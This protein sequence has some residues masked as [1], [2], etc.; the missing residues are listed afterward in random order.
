VEA[1]IAAERAKRAILWLRESAWPLWLE[2]GV[3]WRKRA[4]HE[5]LRLDSLD[6]TASFRRLR[7]A[8]R[9]TYVFSKAAGHG[10]PRAKEAVELG[11]GFLRGPARLVEGGVAWRFDLDS[12]PVDLTRDLYDHAF[13]LLAFSAAAPVMGPDSLRQDACQL[14]DYIDTRFRHAE[15][16]Y[17]ESIPST[18]P[19]RQNPHMHLLEA[20][21]AAHDSFGEVVYFERAQALI[22]LFLDRFFQPNDGALPEYFDGRLSP[23]REQNRQYIIEPGHHYEW[24]W[25]LDWYAKSAAAMSRQ[26]RPELGAASEALLKFTDRFAVDRS[27]GLVFNE[28]WSDGSLRSGDFR[29]W[30]QTE[31]LKAEARR[32]EHADKCTG[33]AFTAL[34]KHL[35][36]V[37]PGLWRERINADGI[38]PDDPAPAT[39]LYHLTAALT[40]PAVVAYA[41][42][43]R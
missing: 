28:L 7:V 34:W 15:A 25:L 24:I 19:R 12:K 35:D 38:C 30:P 20:L 18:Q 42:S 31:R 36:G 26:V 21:L 17:E 32:H 9:Q 14:L 5:H 4:F 23:L 13:V 39:S 8:A 33:A 43:G 2:H 10:V 22:D 1:D 29:L 6:C 40:D 11:L 37:R 27:S 41:N 16:G 3:D